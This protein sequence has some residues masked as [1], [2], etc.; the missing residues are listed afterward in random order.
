M[1]WYIFYRLGEG[2]G[3]VQSQKTKLYNNSR[4]VKKKD[5]HKI[6]NITNSYYLC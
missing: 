1:I 2:G 5:L 6:Q 3:G 4:I